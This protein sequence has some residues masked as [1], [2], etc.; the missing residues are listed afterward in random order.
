MS[1]DEKDYLMISG[2][3]H[4]V[5]CKRQWALDHIENQWADNY[6]TVSGNRLHEKADDPYISELVSVMLSSFRRI[7]RVFKYLVKREN[8]CLSLLN[9]SMENLK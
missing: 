8:I 6:L 4:F 3:Q 1:Y 7:L 2:I 5:F 9:I